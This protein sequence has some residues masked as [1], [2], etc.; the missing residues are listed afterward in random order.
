MN[1]HLAL[2]VLWAAQRGSFLS[3]P[4]QST[5][6]WAAWLGRCRGRWEAPHWALGGH[7]RDADPPVSQTPSRSFL[8]SCWVTLQQSLLNKSPKPD[9]WQVNSTK[10]LNELTPVF[11]ELFQKPEEEGMLSNSFYMASIT[12]YQYRQR[13]H[14]KKK[15]KIVGQ[16]H[17]WW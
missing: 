13:H 10:H 8:M 12:R 2:A 17:L 4:I 3:H 11:L 7:Q 9:A 5:D 16:Y 6:L 1:E 14:L 15:K